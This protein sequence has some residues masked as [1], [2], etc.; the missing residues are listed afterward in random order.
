MTNEKCKYIRVS[1]KVGCFVPTE[2]TSTIK[3][4]NFYVN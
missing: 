4:L 2:P 3:G 1:R